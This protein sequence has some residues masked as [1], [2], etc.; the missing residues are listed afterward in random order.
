MCLE[1]NAALLNKESSHAQAKQPQRN[2]KTTRDSKGHINLN[3]EKNG[4]GC[5]VFLLIVDPTPIK[6]LTT[7]KLSKIIRTRITV[8]FG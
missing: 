4:Q 1:H 3:D 6:T 8:H 5:S 7:S 2:N